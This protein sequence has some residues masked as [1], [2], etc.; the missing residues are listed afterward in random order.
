L[1]PIAIGAMA[2]GAFAEVVGIR[3]SLG[4]CA[5]GLAVWGLWSLTH[6]VPAIDGITHAAGGGIREG[7][8]AR[9]HRPV[10]Q[11]RQG[12]GR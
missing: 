4:A 1:G 12:S 8:F 10:R 7:L 2:A 3:W 11:N 6:R 9:R 5:A